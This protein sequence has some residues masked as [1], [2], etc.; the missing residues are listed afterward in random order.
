M[1]ERATE[2]PSDSEFEVFTASDGEAA[3]RYTPKPT[4]GPPFICPRC[5]RETDPEWYCSE[6]YC[7]TCCIATDE[8]DNIHA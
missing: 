1:P 5:G 8:K 6:G 2:P 3:I 4:I 7:P